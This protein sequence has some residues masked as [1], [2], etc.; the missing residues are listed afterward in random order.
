MSTQDKDEDASGT[1]T[2]AATAEETWEPRALTRTWRRHLPIRMKTPWS[3]AADSSGMRT[4]KH[5]EM[6]ASLPTPRRLRAGA[7][8]TAL[9]NAAHRP[10]R[11]EQVIKVSW[12]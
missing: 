7:G 6:T 4:T 10:N 11:F 3:A 12:T 9:L 8:K 5:R 1:P 2:E